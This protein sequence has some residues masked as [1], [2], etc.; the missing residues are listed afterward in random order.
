MYDYYNKLYK[1]KNTLKLVV[2]SSVDKTHVGFNF[3]RDQ[4]NK[5]NIKRKKVN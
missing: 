4:N 5:K 2:V 1:T 3:D